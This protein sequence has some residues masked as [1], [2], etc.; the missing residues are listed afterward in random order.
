M[1]LR[2]SPVWATRSDRDCGPP[3]VEAANDRAQ[4]RAPHALAPLSEVDPACDAPSLCSSLSNLCETDLTGPPLSS[5]DREC[6]GCADAERLEADV[7]NKLR[8]GVLSTARIATEKVIPGMRRAARGEVVAIA[9][10]DAAGARPRPSGSASRARH[11]SYEAL[12]ADPEVDAVYI[13]LPNHLHAEWTIAAAR[14]GKHV[15]CEKPLALTAADAERDGRRLPSGRG[16][17]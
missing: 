8:W 2:V 4:V 5:G 7:V 12:L 3:L 13:P 11:G 16:G 6:T 15:L 1:A 14:A 9:S 17:S 10:R